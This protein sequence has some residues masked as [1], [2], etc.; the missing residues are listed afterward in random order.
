MMH[1]T[2]H[3]CPPN[4]T[5][6]PMINKLKDAHKL[7]NLSLI[8][9][10]NFDFDFTFIY[11]FNFYFIIPLFLTSILSSQFSKNVQKS[12]FH[13]LSKSENLLICPALIGM[14]HALHVRPLSEK[15]MIEFPFEEA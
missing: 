15:I 5:N 14:A 11:G 7:S 12:S 13:L 2:L 4:E 6:F 9:C 1:T 3:K 8:Y 10:V